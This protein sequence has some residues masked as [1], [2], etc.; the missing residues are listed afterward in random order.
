[1]TLMTNI[2]KMKQKERLCDCCEVK[3]NSY[4][5]TRRCFMTGEY[6]S[7]LVNIQ[8]ERR[9]LHGDKN[10]TITINAFV[11]MNF[12]DMSDVVYEWKIKPFVE[13]L[14]KYFSYN[15]EML[16]CSVCHID[17]T[18][19]EYNNNNIN[20]NKVRIRVVRSDTDPASN[21]VICNRICQ[22][23]QI[24]DIVIVDVSSQNPNVFYEFG[25][26]LAL[27]KLILPICY[28]GSFYKM[29]IPFDDDKI[30]GKGRKSRLELETHIG[31]YPWRKALYEYYGIRYKR[32]DSKTE[33]LEY[34]DVEI[35]DY[36]FDDSKYSRFPY[37]EEING[38]HIGQTIYN[39]LRSGYNDNE[40]DYNTVVVYTMEGFLNA[41]QSGRCIVN[42]YNFIVKPMIEGECFCGERVGVLVQHHPIPEND[43]DAAEKLQLLYNTGEIIHIGV[44]EATFRIAERKV[45]SPDVF[46]KP[47]HK[48]WFDQDIKVPLKYQEENTIRNI[49]T[50]ITNRGMIIYPKDPIYVERIRNQITEDLL[51]TD[52]NSDENAGISSKPFCLYHVMLRTLRYVNQLV[53]D[54]SDNSTQALFWL[55]TA[56]GSDIYAITVVHEYSDKERDMLAPVIVKKNRNVF[57]VAGLWTSV[58][59]SNDTKGFYQQLVMAQ[60]GIERHSK[61]MLSEMEWQHFDLKGILSNNNQYSENK[62]AKKILEKLEE[63]K[64]KEKMILESYYRKRFWSRM[65]RY[66][67]LH[68]YLEQSDDQILFIVPNKPES[69]KPELRA[70][71]P[72]W[73]FEA[74]SVLTNYLSTHTVIGEYRLIAVQK[75]LDDRQTDIDNYIC[76]G[77]QV[78]V[79]TK[80]M[81]MIYTKIDAWKKDPSK[82][83]GED[84]NILHKWFSEDTDSCIKCTRGDNLRKWVGFRS[85]G[86]FLEDDEALKTKHYNHICFRCEAEQNTDYNEIAQLIL[87]RDDSNSIYAPNYFRVSLNGASGTATYALSKIFVDG[88][89]TENAL[90]FELQNEVRNRFMDIYLDNLKGAI[91]NHGLTVGDGENVADS[92]QCKSYCQLVLYTVSMYLSTVLYRYFF[93]FLSN[94]DQARIY[95]DLHTYIYSMRAS[96]TSPFAEN[97]TKIS[98]SN[99]KNPISNDSVNVVIN[100]ILSELKNALKGF[101]GFEAFFDVEVGIHREP[102]KHQDRSLAEKRYVKNI[103]LKQRECGMH[104]INYFSDLTAV[105][106]IIND[107]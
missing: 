42:F 46:C 91:L 54:L 82:V 34:K 81:E 70:R 24:A 78:S 32:K 104:I 4:V 19:K 107:Q 87:W 5:Q 61:L 37:H 102:S 40:Y 64:I 17:G 41:E 6:C 35:S 89:L 95:N 90:L 47:D 15:N 28:S 73:D 31:C 100:L 26:A 11:I 99:F 3:I 38:L 80:W 101:K 20:H 14:A 12:S 79:A 58:Y 22:Q 57:D 68:I 10:N 9:R 96:N 62:L 86:A 63:K 98:T 92:M 27:G 50:Y 1:M 93:P 75:A 7:Q 60:A 29:N 8:Q 21:Y 49:K 74:A 83:N 2:N 44:N 56:H 33:Y 16:K 69:N 13:S 48:S 43:K 88:K 67:R 85:R 55:G 59:H 52:E 76:I 18:E 65:L 106:A 77:G 45:K 94:R 30:K 25:M 39:K 103:K 53:V 71:I 23:L 66:N 97:Y 84:I 36:G 72:K 51:S 105:N